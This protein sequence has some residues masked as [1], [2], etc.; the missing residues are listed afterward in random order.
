METCGIVCN[1][2]IEK[3]KTLYLKPKSCSLSS[4]S[5]TENFRQLSLSLTQPSSSFLPSTIVAQQSFNLWCPFLLQI[6]KGGH[7]RN[8]E[9]RVYEWDFETS[10]LGGLLSLLI[11]IVMA[12]QL[13]HD[14]V[15]MECLEGAWETLEGNTRCRFRGTIRFKATSLV[16][17]DE[18]ARTL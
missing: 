15:E 2:I 18:P 5:K 8:R 17:P 7:F 16:H 9:V 1:K 12:A 4:L 13:I 14:R 3:E 11:F 10:G 6:A